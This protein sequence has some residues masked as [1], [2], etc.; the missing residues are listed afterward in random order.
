MIVPSV[1][2]GPYN[3]LTRSVEFDATACF[4]ELGIR[5]YHY[6]PLAGGLL[7]GKV[8][9]HV[10][11]SQPSSSPSCHPWAVAAHYTCCLPWVCVLIWQYDSIESQ[12]KDAGRFG[13]CSP[14]S[15]AAYSQRYWKQHIFDA[16]EL[17]K[18]ACIEADVVQENQ[19]YILTPFW[20]VS[21]SCYCVF[22]LQLFINPCK[23]IFL[24]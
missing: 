6:N 24:F 16:I 4:R 18:T 11:V 12:L 5:S 21:R 14:I 13:S 23:W 8:Y 9:M 19:Q 1:Y 10:L 7:T 20:Y 22:S 3:A 15:G 17:V 2:Q